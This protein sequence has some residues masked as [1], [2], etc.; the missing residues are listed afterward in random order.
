MPP[1]CVKFA[2]YTSLPLPLLGANMAD[3]LSPAEWKKN[4]NSLL[5]LLHKKTGLTEAL[6]KYDTLRKSSKTPPDPKVESLDAVLK[7][8]AKTAEGHKNK[9]AQEYLG[10]MKAQ[11]AKARSEAAAVSDLFGKGV[12]YKEM[13]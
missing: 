2:R 4:V 13:L 7:A 10:S 3:F 6:T 8:I 11:A 5:G 12:A 1:C 9:K